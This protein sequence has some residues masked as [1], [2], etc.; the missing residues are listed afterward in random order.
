MLSGKGGITTG[1]DG[2]GEGECGNYVT[3]WFKFT[4]P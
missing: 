2:A 3:S 4:A 1:K